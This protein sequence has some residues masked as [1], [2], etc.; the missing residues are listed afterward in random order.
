M[1]EDSSTL[2]VCWDS[3]KVLGL[4]DSYHLQYRPHVNNEGFVSMPL[5]REMQRL[6]GWATVHQYITGMQYIAENLSSHFT[7]EFRV[8]ARNKN[9]YGPWS[10]VSK[11]F[12]TLPGPPLIT[13]AP[14]ATS[15]KSDFMKLQWTQ[16]YHNG[17][18][19]IEYFLRG[20]IS[21]R[22]RS[23]SPGRKSPSPTRS[24]SPVKDV[25]NDDRHLEWEIFY[26]G[27]DC[28]A[29]IN[30]LVPGQK[31]QFQLMA[32]NEIGTSAWGAS[33]YYRTHP[34][35]ISVAGLTPCRTRSGW[36]EYFIVTRDSLVYLDVDTGI[37]VTDPPL[38]FQDQV[39][40]DNPE[41]A[42][43]K[44]RFRLLK[45]LRANK[46]KTRKKYFLQVY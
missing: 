24:P 16:G 27:S 22:R 20:K 21:A 32:R 15:V 46:D 42:L 6:N 35:H 1:D 17:N 18:A 30:D 44:K 38:C 13:S 31:Y 2:T 36:E 11:P 43:R 40:E 14:W 23:S 4:V 29:D 25:E 10:E 28:K 34:C 7:A 8:R 5:Q 26:Q 33:A 39:K 37:I 45:S 19:I 12:T 3:V 9:G 41:I